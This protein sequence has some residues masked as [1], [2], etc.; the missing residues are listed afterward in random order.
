MSK[1]LQKDFILYI[2]K[3]ILMIHISTERNH[4]LVSLQTESFWCNDLWFS[5]WQAYFTEENSSDSHF[6]RRILACI[7]KAIFLNNWYFHRRKS[8]SYS[9]A[10][11]IFVMYLH[12]VFF[13]KRIRLIDSSTEGFHPVYRDSSLFRDWYFLRKKL[14]PCPFAAGIFLMY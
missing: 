1:T 4:F 7:W 2:R 9:S 10:E 12:L 14:F 13:M 8:F 5:F 6:S 3:N 11:R